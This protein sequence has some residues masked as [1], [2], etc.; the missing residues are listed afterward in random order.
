MNI[1]ISSALFYP[2]KLGG[3]SNTL[4]WLSKGLVKAGHNV[5]VVTTNNEITDETI[6]ADEWISIDGIKVLYTRAKGKLPLHQIAETAKV[7]ADQ[8]VVLLTSM[9]YLPELPIALY[10]IAKRKKI[11]WSPRGEFSDSAIGGSF[12]KKLYFKIVKL[13]TQH[14][15]TYHATSDDEEA[16]IHTILGKNAR[17]I[18]L[19]N[20]LEVPNKHERTP[21][22]NPYLLFLG[23]VAPIKAIDHLIEACNLSTSF[24][25]SKYKLKI[26]GGI[27]N[28]F[29][30]Y[31][32]KLVSMI[33]QYKLEDKIEFIGAVSGTHKFQTY[34]DAQY[35][36]L[37]SHSEN[38]GNV[39]I[40]SLSQ[41]TPVVASHGTPWK[42]LEDENAGHWIDNSPQTIAQSIDA[43]IAEN[44]EE[45]IKKRENAYK[46]SLEYDVYHNIDKWIDVMAK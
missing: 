38:F 40:E 21:N 6:K 12:A 31:H 10:C 46:L 15:V 17:V 22:I 5:T 2:S 3:P 4:Y 8:D 24:R 16:A 41:G 7:V 13:L 26:A 33:Q 9:C 20:Y 27:E 37:V 1:L 44:S 14:H 32:E 35:L 18:Q 30:Q 36:F 43:V 28:Q 42:I 34:C 39:I 23:R 25:N 11:I 19:P 29:K 45:Y